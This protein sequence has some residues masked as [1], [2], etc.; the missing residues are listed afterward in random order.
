MEKQI[1]LSPEQADRLYRFAQ[2]YQLSEDQVI[3]QALELFFSQSDPALLS[4]D[5]LRRVWDNDQ[6]A[7]YDHWQELYDVSKG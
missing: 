5:A 6:D 3:A 7:A 2:T 4:E 1:Q